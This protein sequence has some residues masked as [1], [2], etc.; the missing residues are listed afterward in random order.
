[1]CNNVD[2]SNKPKLLMKK[3]LLQAIRNSVDSNTFRNVFVK[4]DNTTEDVMENGIKSCAFFV[5]GLLAMF[6][7]IDMAH[8]TIKTTEKKLKEYNWQEVNVD[9][10]IDG[11]VIVWE[12]IEFED[13]S[14]NKHIGFY[15]GDNMAISNDMNKKT[16][17]SHDWKFDGK[18]NIEKLLRYNFS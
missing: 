8:A 13:G 6:D 1:M 4:I 7:L 9:T 15:I 11:D 10:P 17:Q 12:E 14:K 2:M 16:P 3:S 5:S 18:R